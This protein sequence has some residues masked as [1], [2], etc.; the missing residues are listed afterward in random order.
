MFL[1]GNESTTNYH[2]VLW[3]LVGATITFCARI[4]VEFGV[5]I[6]TFLFCRSFSFSS[7]PFVIVVVDVVFVIFWW[8]LSSA[9][10]FVVRIV[11][12]GVLCYGM[13]LHVRLAID[14]VVAVG[15]AT[16]HSLFLVIST[17]RP[18]VLPCCRQRRQFRWGNR[19]NSDKMKMINKSLEFHAIPE[20]RHASPTHTHIWCTHSYRPQNVN[21]A[22]RWQRSSFNLL[23]YC[24]SL[25][26]WTADKRSQADNP[27]GT[28]RIFQEN[29]RSHN[30]AQIYTTNRR[31]E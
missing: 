21:G 2:P 19:L 27:H 26:R 12:A 29:I 16:F 7:V 3:H 23:N 8:F 9:L 5:S 15:R 10:F 18:V 28:R 24:M 1:H 20:T 4:I 22:P 13:F 30:P 6:K 17:R 14:S 11:C 25:W 31:N